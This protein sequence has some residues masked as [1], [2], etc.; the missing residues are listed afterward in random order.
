[1]TVGVIPDENDLELVLVT[2]GTV[3]SVT[4]LHEVSQERELGDS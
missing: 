2:K 4:E 3:A 1:L